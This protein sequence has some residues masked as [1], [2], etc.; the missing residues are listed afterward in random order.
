MLSKHAKPY[1]AKVLGPGHLLGRQIEDLVGGNRVSGHEAQSLINSAADAGVDELR[2]KRK[3]SSSKNAARDFKRSRHKTSFWPQTYTF[4]GPLY[5]PK[6][7]AHVNADI[8]LW[9][10]LELLD[11]IHRL[12]ESSAIG[13]ETNMDPKT[14]Q[15]LH[16]QRQVHGLPNLLGLGMH[17]DGIP[18]NYD[19]TESC[20]AVTLNLPGL[21]DKWSRMRIPIM[22]GPSKLVTSETMD[23]ILEV[24]AWSIRHCLAGVHPECRHDGTQWN[25]SDKVRAGKSGDLGFHATLVEVRGDWDWYSKIFHFPYHGELDGIC[26]KCPCKRKEAFLQCVIDLQ[27]PRS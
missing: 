5:D 2:S 13:D 24:L 11:M 12:G 10:P 23:S 1:D 4:K 16:S 17:M 19:R 3:N 7:K 14:K 25:E 15:H 27:N 20:F 8:V 9:L 22:V 21:G 26:W 6:K 18:N